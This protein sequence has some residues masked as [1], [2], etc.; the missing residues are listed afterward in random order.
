VVPPEPNV[1]V[2]FAKDKCTYRAAGKLPLGQVGI[3]W[4][5][6]DKNHDKFGLAVLTLDQGKSI[7]DLEA[8]TSTDQPPWSQLVAFHEAAPGSRSIVT[9][10]VEEGPI[11]FACFTAYPEQIVGALGPLEVK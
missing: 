7:K 8:W 2:I 4:I 5:V 9:A 11:Y 3:D 6:E 1:T 10:E